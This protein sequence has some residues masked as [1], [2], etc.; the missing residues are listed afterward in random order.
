MGLTVA[1]RHPYPHIIGPVS[2]PRVHVR[3]AT[4]ARTAQGTTT[5]R[6]LC[7]ELPVDRCVGV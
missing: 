7:L 6:S 3:P 1:D 2:D 4:E 5:Q